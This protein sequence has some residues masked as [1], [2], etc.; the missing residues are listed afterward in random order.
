MMTLK[1]G[2]KTLGTRLVQNLGTISKANLKTY[3]LDQKN[4]IKYSRSAAQKKRLSWSR[5][6]KKLW[7]DDALNE[8]GKILLSHCLVDAQSAF[9][10]DCSVHGVL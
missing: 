8:L 2:K 3:P 6:T 7:E 1:K 10:C 5:L 9:Q 4:K